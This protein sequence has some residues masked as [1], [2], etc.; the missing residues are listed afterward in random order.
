MI[1]RERVEIEIRSL[2]QNDWGDWRYNIRDV[3]HVNH[4]GGQRGHYREGH[5]RRIFISLLDECMEDIPSF[6][7][8]F[9][10]FR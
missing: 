2:A 6:P 3:T 9:R 8:D 5:F 1:S 10:F 7:I 4:Q